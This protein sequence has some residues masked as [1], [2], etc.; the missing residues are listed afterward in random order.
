MPNSALND[1]DLLK[2][3]QHLRNAGKHDQAAVIR[4]ILL[5]KDPNDPYWHSLAAALYA[6]DE[7]YALAAHERNVTTHLMTNGYQPHRAEEQASFAI[8]LIYLDRFDEAQVAIDRS[9]EIIPNNADAI[10][11]SAYLLWMRDDNENNESQVIELLRN[12][13]AKA[14]QR[15][16]SSF[17]GALASYYYLNGKWYLALDIYKEIVNDKEAQS[18]KYKALYMIGRIYR[19]LKIWKESNRY[20]LSSLHAR[21]KYEN[22]NLEYLLYLVDT[23][24]F[25][26]FDEH[27][28]TLREEEMR[29][30]WKWNTVKAYYWSAKGEYG[31]ATKIFEDDVIPALPEEFYAFNKFH[32]DR[33]YFYL[34]KHYVKIGSF[35]KAIQYLATVVHDWRPKW[36]QAH[37]LYQYCLSRAYGDVNWN[38]DLL[39]VQSVEVPVQPSKYKKISF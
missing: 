35:K 2:K 7:L 30:K 27:L 38:M 36:S 26:T 5:S 16:V 10:K 8:N 13:I 14:T 21:A 34:A 9:L 23:K 18:V 39:G 17:K 37:V 4:N 33:V 29:I 12:A 32:K 19:E 22:S 28:S 6:D 20:L 31:A 25:K 11:A 1:P 3:A 24:Q 15:T